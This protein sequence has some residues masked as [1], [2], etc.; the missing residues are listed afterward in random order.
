MNYFLL[1]WCY[2]VMDVMDVF[3]KGLLTGVIIWD[4]YPPRLDVVTPLT[5]QDNFFLQINSIINNNNKK[6]KKTT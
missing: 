4:Y 1:I 5:D 2:G 6:K 3:A